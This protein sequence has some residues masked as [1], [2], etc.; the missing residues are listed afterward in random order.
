M[1]EVAPL[2]VPEAATKELELFRQMA[3][4]LN[5]EPFRISHRRC[6]D[7][8]QGED[9]RGSKAAHWRNIGKSLEDECCAVDVRDLAAAGAEIFLHVPGFL[10]VS[11]VLEYHV[12][13]VSST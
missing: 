13:T 6:A 1:L 8:M 3:G 11:D 7:G 10:P 5:T 4:L 9:P 12:R 2:E